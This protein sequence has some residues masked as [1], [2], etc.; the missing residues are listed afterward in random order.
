VPTKIS[1]E[2]HHFCQRTNKDTRSLHLYCLEQDTK[3]LVRTRPV[4]VP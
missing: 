2:P 1:N 4:S 3:L